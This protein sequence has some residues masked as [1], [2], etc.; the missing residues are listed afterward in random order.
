MNDATKPL[1]SKPMMK[2]V[3][4]NTERAARVPFGRYSH[5]SHDR[6]ASH[7]DRCGASHMKD[8]IVLASRFADDRARELCLAL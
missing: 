6:L 2:D 8:L 1:T 4:A 7:W 5:R 3:E